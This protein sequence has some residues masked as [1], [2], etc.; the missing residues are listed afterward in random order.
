M[1]ELARK[2]FLLKKDENI[3]VKEK[4]WAQQLLLKKDNRYYKIYGENDSFFFNCLVRKELADIYNRLGIGWEVYF[5]EYQ[6][7]RYFIEKREEL[8]RLPVDSTPEVVLNSWRE[9][10]EELEKRLNLDDILE[11]LKKKSVSFRAVYRIRLL[12]PSVFKVGDW[13][14]YGDRV[15]LLDD[16]NF[17]LVCVNER[18][19]KVE[20]KNSLAEEVFYRGKEVIFVGEGPITI[21]TIQ[22]SR[23]RFTLLEKREEIKGDIKKWEEERRDY[24]SWMLRYLTKGEEIV[25]EEKK[26]VISEEDK[27][28]YLHNYKRKTFQWELWQRCNQCCQFCYLGNEK[29]RVL[30]ERQLKSLKDLQRELAQLDC[31]EYNC[32][33]L[34]GGEFFQGQLSTP[35]IKELFYDCL[36]HIA[37]MY[38]EKK[39]GSFW[40]SVTLTSRN[41]DDLYRFLDWAV[42]NNMIS[43]DK[44]FGSSGLWLCTS[45]DARG[46][47]HTEEQKKI[48]EENMLKIQQKYDMVKFNT[49]IILTEP[50]IEQYLSGEFSIK[51]FKKKYKTT[52]FFKQPGTGSNFKLEDYGLKRENMEGTYAQAMYDAKQAANKFYGWNF[53]P[54][55]KIFLQFLNK[56]KNEDPE[57]YDRLFNIKYRAEELY[58]N[59][60][61]EGEANKNLRFKDNSGKETT[62]DKVL[63][64]CGH[65]YNYDCYADDPEGHCCICDRDFFA[66]A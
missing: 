55:R 20:I 32:V 27:E 29:I 42:V 24:E 30:E 28:L 25:M 65:S 64:K 53:F 40:I 45:W 56:M 39:I 19:D 51:E 62:E 16:E 18:G 13:A 12:L 26:R 37:G 54:H 14:V 47:F 10:H 44:D 21:D 5:R 34:I 36:M 8:E 1:L 9:I 6:G 15:I 7:K 59:F 46:R 43:P 57:D 66:R 35:E 22:E 49:T 38:S 58:R 4:P 2:E 17:S 60:N 61:D 50:F 41:Q 48:W 31:T 23:D 63:N 3:I 52:L 33:S 11:Q